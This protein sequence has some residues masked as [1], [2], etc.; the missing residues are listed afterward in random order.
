MVLIDHFLFFRH[1]SKY[2]P[3]GTIARHYL[4]SEFR[5]RDYELDVPTF[6]Q[7]AAF[8]GICVWL[9]PFGLFISLSAGELTLPTVGS[10]GRM[11]LPGPGRRSQGLVKQVVTRAGNWINRKLENLGWASGAAGGVIGG[12]DRYR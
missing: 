5:N 10:D 6:G 9:V 1:F 7:V 3:R 4:T 12:Y 2:P 11:G 8:F